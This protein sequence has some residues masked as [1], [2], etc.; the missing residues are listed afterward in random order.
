[1][2]FELNKIYNIDCMEAFLKM[3][4]NSVDMILTDIPYGEVNRYG[5]EDVDNNDIRQFHKGKADMVTF[6]VAEFVKQCA[7]VCSGN[8]YIFCGT[9]QVSEI[10]RTF[11]ELGLSTRH[12]VWEKTNPSPTNGQYMWLSNIENCIYAKKSGSVHNEFCKGAVWR[13]PTTKS[14]IHPTQKPIKLFRYLINASSNESMTILDPCIGSGTTAIACMDMG[15][16]FIGFE[17]DKEYFDL[18]N[19]RIQAEQSQIRMF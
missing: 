12:C 11:V 6:N 8:V 10:R 17:L 9:E 4:D 1:M 16:N 7:R 13:Y 3:P 15:R 19:E 2:K 14:D 18:A 5:N